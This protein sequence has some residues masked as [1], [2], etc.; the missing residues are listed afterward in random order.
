MVTVRWRPHDAQCST[1][2]DLQVGQ[3]IPGN[4]T[5]STQH[6]FNRNSGFKIS[7]LV[8][9]MRSIECHSGFKKFW[10][11]VISVTGPSSFA[12]RNTG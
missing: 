3:V 4:T 6:L 12:S 9:G 11:C 2:L 7:S 10:F 1:T 5:F 8:G